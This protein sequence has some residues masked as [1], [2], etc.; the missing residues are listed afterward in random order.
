MSEDKRLKQTNIPTWAILLLV[1]VV[2]ALFS[3]AMGAVRGCFFPVANNTSM[4]RQIQMQRDELERV[5]KSLDLFTSIVDR[6]DDQVREVDDNVRDYR[7]TQI[8]RIEKIATVQNVIAKD[9]DN[10][11]KWFQE[12]IPELKAQVEKEKAEKETK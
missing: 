5:K 12:N 6:L 11:K 9:W 2:G 8:D 7:L 1:L 3:S 10:W 4:Q